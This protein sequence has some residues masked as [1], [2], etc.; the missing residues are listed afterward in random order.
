MNDLHRT[1]GFGLTHYSVDL[2]KKRLTRL[3]E[4]SPFLTSHF[5]FLNNHPSRFLI[6]YLKTDA[7]SCG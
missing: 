4:K 1:N 6:Q 7:D 3:I 2:L 5:S